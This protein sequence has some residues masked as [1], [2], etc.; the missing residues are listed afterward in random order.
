MQSYFL[1]YAGYFRLMCDVDAFVMVTSVQFPRRGW[2]HR[3]RLRD[4]SGRL[5]WLT[6][7]LAAMPLSTAIKDIRYATGAEKIL[8]KTSRRFAACRVPREHVAPLVDRALRVDAPPVM[9]IETLL[10]E[11]AAI[12]GLSAPLLKESSL[13]LPSH[14]R[15]QERAFAIC[16]ALGAGVYVNSP[17]GRRLY[18][19]AEFSKRGLKLEFLSQYRGDVASILQ[20]LHDSTPADI[21]AEIRANMT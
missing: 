12:L 10:R 17:G 11:T 18:D 7:P 21:C 19:P 20:R 13:N 15:G 4:D 14:L 3:N 2:V 1:P 16:A 6:L 8:L 9:A 5:G